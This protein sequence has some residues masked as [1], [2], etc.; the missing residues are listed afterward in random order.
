MEIRYPGMSFEDAASATPEAAKEAGEK[1]EHAL[2]MVKTHVCDSIIRNCAE[3]P[4][5]RTINHDLLEEYWHTYYQRVVGKLHN[6]LLFLGE[7]DLIDP[8]VG[9]T[10]ASSMNFLVSIV[11][12]L[13]SLAKQNS[14]VYFQETLFKLTAVADQCKMWAECLPETILTRVENAKA[15]HNTVAAILRAARSHVDDF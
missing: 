10:V 6:I 15:Q 13:I 1:L 12:T 2:L 7:W 4:G 5:V 8:V 14:M 3:N 9:R 11:Q